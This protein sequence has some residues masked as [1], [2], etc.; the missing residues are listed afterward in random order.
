MKPAVRKV[1]VSTL[2]VFWLVPSGGEASRSYKSIL[3]KWTRHDRVFVWD[4]LEARMIWHATYFSHE[5]REARRSRL[6]GLYE[7]GETEGTLR[8]QED[9]DE[10][11]QFDVFFLGI[12][13]GSSQWP[14]VGKDDGRWR[15]VLEVEGRQPVEAVRLER[16][17]VSQLERTLYPYLDKW[18]EGYLVRFPKVISSGDLFRLRMTGIPARS[19]LVWR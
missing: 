19:E 3:K 7:S 11:E 9:R 14:E 12:Y 5:F 1:V 2:L 15:M 10:S 13:A 16:V 8:F 18:S 4:N 6:A 17:K